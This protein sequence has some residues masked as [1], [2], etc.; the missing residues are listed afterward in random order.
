MARGGRSFLPVDREVP[1]EFPPHR[2]AEA[3]LR[4]VASEVQAQR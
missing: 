2:A 4:P 1:E 3:D